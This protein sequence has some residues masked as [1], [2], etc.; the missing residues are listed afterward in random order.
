MVETVS[1][2]SRGVKTFTFLFTLYHPLLTTGSPVGSATS[3]LNVQSGHSKEESLLRPPVTI[4][5]SSTE[6]CD[7]TMDKGGRFPSY[8]RSQVVSCPTLLTLLTTIGIMAVNL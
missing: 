7:E 6:I 2:W 5:A 3:E 1:E 8:A 4:M